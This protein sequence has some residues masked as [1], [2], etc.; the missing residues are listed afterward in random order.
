MPNA[1]TPLRCVSKTGCC[2]RV[3]KLVMQ[4][5]KLSSLPHKK[6]FAKYKS[7]FAHRPQNDKLLKM[8]HKPMFIL[9]E[10]PE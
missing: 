8:N 2:S 10:R 1:V 5:E 4:S 6:T 9:S 7:Y 3:N